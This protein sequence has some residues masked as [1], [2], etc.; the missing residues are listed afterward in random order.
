MDSAQH[1]AAEVGVH[2]DQLAR[3][4]SGIADDPV[5]SAADMTAK[6]ACRFAQNLAR[7]CGYAVFP[8]GENKPPTRPKSEGGEGWKDG[9]TDPDRISWL[10][11]RW[12]GPLIGIV[13]GEPSGIS[14]LDV[15]R[16]C[17]ASVVW[18]R[19]NY[20]RLLPTRVYETRGGGLHV[21]FRH[22]EGI[23]NT[24]GK[25]CKGVDT[26]GEGGYIV[27][28]YSAGFHCF[29]HSPP[30]PWPAWLLDELTRAPIRAEPPHSAKLPNTD[31]VLAG[32]VHRVAVA[33]EGERNAVLFW[34]ACRCAERGIRPREI[35]ALLLPAAVGSGLPDIEARRTISSAAG[36][37]AR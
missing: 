10:W 11:L 26:R 8:V 9:S 27:S 16:K 1:R 37:T 22:I 17:T 18:W 33:T 28:W 7:N 32:I 31:R 36:R 15:D 23:R 34:G 24:Q 35:E 19:E 4:P 14:V 3:G 25:L 2:V 13:T 30:A 6:E 21:Y 29:D 5:H 12:P 20:A